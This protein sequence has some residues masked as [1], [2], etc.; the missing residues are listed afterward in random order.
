MVMGRFVAQKRR[1]QWLKGLDF[2]HGFV[3]VKQ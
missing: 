1:I 2:Q 3:T